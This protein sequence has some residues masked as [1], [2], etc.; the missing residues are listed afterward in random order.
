[1][2]ISKRLKLVAEYVNGKN[3]IDIGCDHAYL[4][5]YLIKNGIIDNALAC[6]I[7]AKAIEKAKENIEKQGYADRI[8][9]VVSDGLKMVN[10]QG[11]D[12]ISICGMG[13]TT[14]INIL[15][16][17]KLFLENIE[18]IIISP[19]SE[20]QYCIDEI[21]KL[22]F[23]VKEEDFIEDHGKFYPIFSLEKGEYQ[24]FTFGQTLGNNQ[25]YKKYI[26]QKQNKLRQILNTIEDSSKNK[27]KKNEKEKTLENLS[28]EHLSVE[29][30][31][32]TVSD[33]IKSLEELSPPKYAC[34]W[35][36]VGLLVGERNKIVKK[37]LVAVEMSLDVVDYA[38]ENNV[39]MVV[40]HHPLIFKKLDR[41]V[42]E[43]FI[44]NKI[45]K[46]IK[47]DIS[48]YA[49]HT[50]F[51]ICGSM[52]EF[53]ANKLWLGDIKPLLVTHEDGHG[54]GAVGNMA[55]VNLRSFSFVVKD[56]FDI[57]IL[58][59]YGD[60]NKLIN[61]VAI[62]PGSCSM[63]EVQAAIKEGADLIIGGDISH[64]TG[65]DALEQG[66]F[67]IDAGHYGVEKI[68]VEFIEDYL[69]KQFEELVIIAENC[70]EKFEWV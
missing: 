64:H 67:V 21:A 17:S 46:L 32:I 2:R 42:S 70:K 6:D 39:D 61:R 27:I 51:D 60:M 58:R 31:G 63:S 10:T 65:V 52:G 44:G 34:N 28:E 16:E 66:I 26:L 23:Y 1:M 24:E 4:P 62:L 49:M 3:L 40:C 54:L 19:Q 47:N 50:N 11:Y 45:I 37:L 9:T 38:I 53:A 7:S 33:V 22:G 41:I 35:D 57:E 68:F 69:S 25:A 20:I 18:R 8:K 14:I 43:N 29:N 36:N 59:V 5:I 56:T 12:C 15:S 13:A 55:Y 30:L 48:V